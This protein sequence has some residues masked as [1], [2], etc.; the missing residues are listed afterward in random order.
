M[1]SRRLNNKERLINLRKVAHRLNRKGIHPTRLNQP[2]K[3]AD[4]FEDTDAIEDDDNTQKQS[5]NF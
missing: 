4:S 1:H 5:E 2:E 3:T